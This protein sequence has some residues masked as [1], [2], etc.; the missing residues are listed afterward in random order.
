MDLRHW[1]GMSKFFPLKCKWSIRLQIFDG[2]RR[3]KK[4]NGFSFENF[5]PL[6]NSRLLLSRKMFLINVCIHWCR[7]QQLN[8]NNSAFLGSKPDFL[9]LVFQKLLYCVAEATN[10][11]IWPRKC[12]IW[13]KGV[14]LVCNGCDPSCVWTQYTA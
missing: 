9:S 3:K 12:I 1:F 14:P 8:M 13:E 6:F 7:F 4:K 10:L 11:K 2:R 5:G